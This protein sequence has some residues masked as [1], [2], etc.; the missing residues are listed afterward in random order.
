MTYG[1]WIILSISLISVT[2]FMLWCFYRVLSPKN[3]AHP[4]K[5]EK[6]AR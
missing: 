5:K 2:C 6:T 3:T 4:R 1:G